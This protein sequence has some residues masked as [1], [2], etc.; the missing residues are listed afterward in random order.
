MLRELDEVRQDRVFLMLISFNESHSD[1][2]VVGM[3]SEAWKTERI[4]KFY[5]LEVSGFGNF[6]T[7]LGVVSHRSFSS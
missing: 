4:R 2:K 7:R 6:S 1:W 3:P 5:N